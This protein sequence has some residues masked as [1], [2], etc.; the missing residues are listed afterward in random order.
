MIL[1][2]TNEDVVEGKRINKFFEEAGIY[3]VIKAKHP[4]S[5]VATY[6]RGKKCLDVITLSNSIEPERVT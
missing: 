3:N 5:Q 6:D 4:G 2:D 1:G